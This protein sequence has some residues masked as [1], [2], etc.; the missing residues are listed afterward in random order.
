VLEAS[1]RQDDDDEIIRLLRETHLYGYDPLLELAARRAG[2]A[3]VVTHDSDFASVRGL[4]VLTAN[5]R[6]L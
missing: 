5:P 2:I 4:I 1:V 6:M 3:S